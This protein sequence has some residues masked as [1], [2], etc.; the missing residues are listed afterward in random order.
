MFPGHRLPLFEMSHPSP[1][2][3]PILAYISDLR[4]IS[5]GAFSVKI[6]SYPLTIAIVAPVTHSTPILTSMEELSHIAF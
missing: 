4:V 3:L 6:L 1:T 2:L 5:D